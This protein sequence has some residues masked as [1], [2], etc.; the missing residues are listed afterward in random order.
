MNLRRDKRTLKIAAH[1]KRE[2]KKHLE[3]A[4]T[5][6][7]KSTNAWA[8]ATNARINR[9]NKHVAANAAQI[10]A[11]AKKAAKDL[12]GAMNSWNHKIA[13][14]SAG[15]KAANSKLGRQ[16]KAQDK[17]TRAWATNKINAMVASTGAQF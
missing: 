13:K 7:Q 3:L 6:W 2:A 4:V 15:E 1:D 5:A 17:A 11:N 8:A 16:F 10:S 9:M 12:A 14:F